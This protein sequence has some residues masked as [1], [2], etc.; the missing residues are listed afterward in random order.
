MV[1]RGSHS[2]LVISYSRFPS[3]SLCYS[4]GNRD[5]GAIS[6]IG[7]SPYRSIVPWYQHRVASDLNTSPP[8]RH[9]IA[10]LRLNGS[11][12]RYGRTRGIADGI[13]KSKQAYRQARISI[14]LS[15]VQSSV[16]S[17]NHWYGIDAA[18]ASLNGPWRHLYFWKDQYLSLDSEADHYLRISVS[19]TSP[20]SIVMVHAVKTKGQ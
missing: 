2:Y 20:T 3:Y 13:L 17:F 10:R 11:R 15:L 14:T 1:S 6:R 18:V 19:S 16:F 12:S 5:V 9:V 8:L 4:R 7:L